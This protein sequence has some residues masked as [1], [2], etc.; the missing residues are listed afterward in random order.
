MRRPKTRRAWERAETAV[1]DGEP[2]KRKHDCGKQKRQAYDLRQRKPIGE[3]AEET[4]R[5]C[6][7]RPYRIV[8]AGKIVGRYDVSGL[9][10]KAEAWRRLIQIIRPLGCARARVERQHE[11]VA[12]NTHHSYVVGGARKGERR[13]ACDAAL[14]YQLE[15]REL[16]PLARRDA[17]VCGADVKWRSGAVIECFVV[18]R[19][20][21]RFEDDLTVSDHA[22]EGE[23]Q[24][25]ERRG[26]CRQCRRGLH[27]VKSARLAW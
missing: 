26:R 2:A 18:V 11:R 8:H 24:I 25:D 16:E 9:R 3:C 12:F 4:S 20:G 15:S 13:R 10:Q 17:G 19:L 6:H 14:A 23:G 5:E 7:L 1:D 22:A 21:G 27:R